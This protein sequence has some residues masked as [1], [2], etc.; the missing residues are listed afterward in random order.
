M[1]VM[2]DRHDAV[3]ATVEA[4][5]TKRDSIGASPELIEAV[6]PSL[7]E[8]GRQDHL[9]PEESFPVN[10]GTKA[11]I[12]ELSADTDGRLGLYASAGLPGKYQPP[13]DHRTWSLIAGVRGAEHNCYFERTD[14]G[15][16]D[17]G[18]IEPRGE[19][20][21]RAGMANGMM[22]DAFHSIEVIEESPALHLHLYG[23][24]LDRLPGRL[25]FESAAGGEAKRF[26]AKP[27]L[28]TALLSAPVVAEML[29]DGHELALL[30]T[31][32]LADYVPEHLLRATPL[33]LDR[34]ELEARALLPNPLVR[35]VV[36]GT[37]SET[38]R[39][40]GH[41]LR[42]GGYAN[43]AILDG[44]IEAWR[45]A[46]LPLHSGMGTFEK[47]FGEQVLHE[48]DTPTITP[49]ELAELR[50]TSRGAP[51]VDCRPREEFE[52]MRIPGAINAPGMALLPSV[53]SLELA[54][55]MPIV[56]SCAGRTRSL[57]GA[58]T[59]IDAGIPNPVMA[60]DNGVMGWRLA[61][62]SIDTEPS[63]AAPTLEPSSSARRKALERA[64]TLAKSRS[65]PAID[66]R[67]LTEWCSDTSQTTYLFD[68]RSP[69]AF[70]AGHRPEFLSAPGAQ[71]LQELT[72]RVPVIG[73]R[74]VLVD[75]DGFQAALTAHWLTR[76]GYEAA[77][78]TDGLKGQHLVDGPAEGRSLVEPAPTKAVSWHGVDAALA[79]GALLIDCGSSRAYRRGHI[80]GAQHCSRGAI[81]DLVLI[82][83]DKPLLFTSTDGGRARYAAA[84]A[85]AL[86]RSASHL[87]GGN[88]AW[89][90]GDR[91]LVTNDA[92]YLAEPR[93]V[94][95]KPYEDSYDD[96]AAMTAYLEWE[97]ALT[98][99]VSP[100]ERSQ[101]RLE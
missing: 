12:Y 5:R 30:D 13:H 41:L 85:V 22:G 42:R 87:L 99:T 57:V 37:N 89:M 54:D 2:S 21:I 82:S 4:V 72:G 47:A 27:Q 29:S 77:V 25:F 60:L 55:D 49:H 78:L 46:D 74:F 20:T 11:T 65:I 83:P 76:A 69:Q 58:Q 75:D 48:L 6:R 26:M 92:V 44:G 84:D 80:P 98:E 16:N 53:E 73:A 67:T 71:L 17:T 15:D 28:H 88:Q 24:T 97:I 96:T 10:Q 1:S 100:E 101:F 38:A 3:R 94:W 81:A 43:V 56:V 93:D 18:V 51:L 36:I 52:A 91:H 86:G 19:L 62:R 14:N 31:R 39:Q 63:E 66:E 32:E 45:V 61:G 79:A 59:L 33:P 34:L 64:N 8:L 40:A 90:G 95:K 9:F 50:G 70:E 35:V 7:I 23:D 68:V